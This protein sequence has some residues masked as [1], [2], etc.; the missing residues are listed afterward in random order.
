MA[1]RSTGFSTRDQGLRRINPS[2]RTANTQTHRTAGHPSACH[3]EEAVCCAQ[4]VQASE[5]KPRQK[6]RSVHCQ[7]RAWQ[8]CKA[9]DEKIFEGL[10]LCTTAIFADTHAKAFAK[11]L[12]T[13][14]S[15]LV[16]LG[17]FPF[18]RASVIA[19]SLH[20]L[21]LHGLWPLYFFAG[22]QR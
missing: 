5:H 12:T 13:L 11:N 8:C 21:C 15:C 1:I 18:L 7:S 22:R 6:L 17:R 10:L 9:T 14:L 2:D 20:N 4:V 16:C 19:N 3:K